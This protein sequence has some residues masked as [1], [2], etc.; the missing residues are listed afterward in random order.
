MTDARIRR[1]LTVISPASRRRRQWTLPAVGLIATL[2]CAALAL[3]AKPVPH[4][5][6]VGTL[7]GLRTEKVTFRVDKKATTVTGF[8]V[9]PYFPNACGSG[10][11]PPTYRSE[12]AKISHGHFS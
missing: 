10:G 4:T 5:R 11:P 1:V 3:A 2:S 12:R 6:Y 7:K 8:R 9:T